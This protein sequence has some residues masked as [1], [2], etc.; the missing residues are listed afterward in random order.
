MQ[1]V[2]GALLRSLPGLPRDVHEA[3]FLED[4]FD[5]KE[6]DIRLYAGWWS[7]HELRD[8]SRPADNFINAAWARLYL[9][10]KVSAEGP[11]LRWIY[12]RVTSGSGSVSTEALITSI[13]SDLNDYRITNFGS[14]DEIVVG[15]PSVDCP[16]VTRPYLCL[17][18][19]D[20]VIPTDGTHLEVM[21]ATS[22]AADDYSRSLLDDSAALRA[23]QIERGI[24]ENALR[25]KAE[26]DGL[27]DMR[28][29]VDL[30]I[31]NDEPPT[32]DR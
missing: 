11:A 9:P 28:T 18:Q 14:A 4:V 30:S 21:Q 25:Q 27:G 5:W 32:Q 15:T 7:G 16:Q 24:R 22:T 3:D 13:M 8:P 2:I 23:Q 6:A 17:G 12:D 19:W 20:D 26:T 10:I 1:E 29:H 31:G